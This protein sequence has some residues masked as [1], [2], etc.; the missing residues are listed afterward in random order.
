MAVDAWEPRPY[1][2]ARNPIKK[3]VGKLVG[4]LLGATEGLGHY[5]GG[6]GENGPTEKFPALVRG[7]QKVNVDEM[8]LG[9]SG[10]RTAMDG[11]R[12]GQET[13]RARYVINAAGGYSDKI[14]AM[15]GDASFKVS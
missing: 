12:V 15:I 9:G 6:P 11:V 14:S 3:F 10:S 13:V 2:E 7:E 1:V 4:K 5:F 8:K